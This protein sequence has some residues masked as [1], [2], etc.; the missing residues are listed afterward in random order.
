M[1]KYSK[2]KDFWKEN[3]LDIAGGYVLI[4]EATILLD[5]FKFIKEVFSGIEDY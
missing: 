2:M 5:L 4:E 1:N 3:R